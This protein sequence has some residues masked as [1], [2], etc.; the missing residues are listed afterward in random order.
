MGEKTFVLTQ[1]F[2]S[3]TYLTAEQWKCSA[4]LAAQLVFSTKPN[5]PAVAFFSN[6]HDL[7]L[8]VEQRAG[9]HKNRERGGGA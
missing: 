2:L 9:G 3:C 7:I 8:T 4:E 6:L 1:C 5:E